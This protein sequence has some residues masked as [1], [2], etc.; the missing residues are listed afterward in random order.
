MEVSPG[1]LPFPNPRRALKRSA[2]T[3]SLPTPPR[4]HRRHKRG[5]SRGDCDSDSGDEAALE[6]QGSA[7]LSSDEEEDEL[8]RFD[9]RSRKKQRLSRSRGE[10]GDEEAFWLAG[11]DPETRRQQDRDQGLLSDTDKEEEAHDVQSS[12]A[13]LLY[14][15]SLKR[16][17]SEASNGLASPPPSHRKLQ[18]QAPITPPAGTPKPSTSSTLLQTQPASPPKTPRKQIG[19]RKGLKSPQFPIISDSPDNPFYVVPGSP[20]PGE[21][22]ESPRVDSVSPRTPGTGHLER[23]TVTYVFRGVRREYHNPLY[24]HKKN[25]PL[26]PPPQSLLP[27]EHPDYSPPVGCKPTVLFPGAPKG[28]RPARAKGDLADNA[29]T[30]TGLRRSPRRKKAIIGDSDDENE[31][32]GRVTEEEETMIKPRKLNFGLSKNTSTKAKA[33]AAAGND[34]L[35]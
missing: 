14:R 23:P 9:Q 32:Q 33:K 5:R 30:S 25:R 35:F 7:L 11:P 24:D 8:P 19:S 13:P 15:K 27:I 22:S 2:S 10:G 4:T 29:S 34:D 12:S 21:E 18:T 1:N 28:K 3:A 20:S 17:H 16:T 6:N 31:L 26:S